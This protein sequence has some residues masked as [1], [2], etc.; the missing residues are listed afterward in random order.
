[1]QSNSKI[2][3]LKKKLP[4]PVFESID[5]LKKHSSNCFYINKY[6]PEA[7]YYAESDEEIIEVVNFCIKNKMPLIPYGSG[8]SVEGH[9]A[10]I[11]G[12][13]CLNL[14]KMKKIIE[15]NLIDGYVVV[16]AG[17]PYNELN[18][19]LASYGF[20]FPVEAGFG[21]SIGGMVSTNASGAGAT[22]SGSMAKNIMGCNL[23]SYKDGMATKIQLGT[24]SIKSSAGYHLLDLIAGSEGTLGVISD[25]CLKIRKNFTHHKTICCQFNEIKQAIDFVISLKG[26]IQFRRVELLDCLQTEA[27]VTY[28]KITYLY[29]NKNTIIIELAGNEA[30]I[31]EELKLINRQLNLMNIEN[32]K[33]FDD[34][35]SAE[36]IW[37]MRK[38][39]C[40]AAIQFINPQKKA[41]ATDI[42]V[43]LSKLNESIHACYQHMKEMGIIA[44]LVAHVGD[45]NFHFTLL[46]NPTDQ[47][48]LEK[49]KTFNQR[50][51]EE[52][53]KVGGTCTGEHGIG[54][55]KMPYLE[56]EHEN[57][58]FLMSRIKES[59]DPLN[60]FN[61]GKL[62]DLKKHLCHSLEVDNNSLT[63]ANRRFC[64]F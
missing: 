25:V 48:E 7:V 13:I 11:N 6:L 26:L 32:I 12:G 35:K 42:S 16:Q 8:T 29:K 1:M 15:L 55:G 62:F 3:E 51:I 19:Y 24:K 41:M 40:P 58:M 21:A 54:I 31:E 57:S 36:Q 22:D 63:I 17:I 18:E 59:F 4:N 28:S 23:I 64:Y 44:P 50:I 43:P 49:A 27:C 10:A 45:G 46:V 60:I 56:L 39:A 34:K 14:S 38:N 37:M 5:E 9:T 53:L 47:T 61:P 30:V 20:H 33:I 2:E 52:S